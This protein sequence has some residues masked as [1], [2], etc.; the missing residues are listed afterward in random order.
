ML[1]SRLRMWSRTVMMALV[2]SHTSL[3]LMA[4]PLLSAEEATL[5]A[6]WRS[7]FPALDQHVGEKR[8][9]YFDSGATSQKPRGVLEFERLYYER[10]NANVHRG[11]HSLATRATEAYE[12]ARAKVAKLI[13]ANSASEVV[14]TK[15]ATEA[16]NLLA[17]SFGETLEAGDEIVLTMLE[18]HANIVP[19]QLLASRKD[20]IL[21]FVKLDPTGSNIDENHLRSLVTP[22]TKLIAMA[23]VSNVLG[24]ETPV[25]LAVQLAKEQPD[26]AVLIDACQSVPHMVVDVQDLGVDFLAA[27]G[28]KMMGPTGIGFLWGK[29][30]RLNSMPP[31]QGGGEMID[32][33]TLEKTTFAEAPGRF[34][35][36]TPPIAQAVALGAA[37]DFLLDVGMETIHRYETFL[38]AKLLDGLNRRPGLTVYGPKER[39]VALAAFNVD[40][41]HATD[42]AFFLDQ[43]G[44]AVRS[45]HHCTQPLHHDLGIDAGSCRASLALYNT[46]DEIDTFL[47]ALDSS[48]DLLKTS[49]DSDQLFLLSS[50]E[51]DAAECKEVSVKN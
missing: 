5:G 11:A 16:M 1:M 18:H 19:W 26:C 50:S 45:G 12:G 17:H 10:D 35:A 30:D 21:K 32:Q 23:H 24:C 4:P 48:I 9:I 34:E 49:S 8:L 29:K 42:L 22:K 39:D 51:G 36:G 37:V 15:G 25:K 20:V 43:E 41:V 44:V 46:P 14:F 13:N 28:H 7:E 6:V 27:S 38:A 2:F 40:G 3:G 31:F 33:V 47:V